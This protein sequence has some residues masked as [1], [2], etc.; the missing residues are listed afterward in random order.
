MP[1]APPRC[2]ML[3]ADLNY[4][5]PHDL[6]RSHPAPPHLLAST[7]LTTT[8]ADDNGDGPSGGGRATLTATSDSSS[9]VAVVKG[10]ATAA[11]TAAIGYCMRLILST[12]Q[13]D[14]AVR[15]LV[16]FSVLG[17]ERLL[18]TAQPTVTVRFGS[19]MWPITLLKAV[20]GASL[21]GPGN[22]DVSMRL[23]SAATWYTGKD[24]RLR[25]GDYDLV[26]V[27]LHE[28]SHDLFMSG[29]SFDVFLSDDG[30]GYDALVARTHLS[31]FDAF[32]ANA[33]GCNVT[34]YADQGRTRALGTALT[35]NNLC[36]SSGN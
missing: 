13:S 20:N 28:V 4:G 26:T 25:P 5:L 10:Q 6:N 36:F 33:D 19:H 16:H 32:L 24:A 1:P 35:G 23:N 3:R 30:T 31:R 29:S 11:Q 27:C 12:W 18:G 7:A 22:F 15:V 14:T 2:P 21:Q 17:S 34:A 8:A 9:F